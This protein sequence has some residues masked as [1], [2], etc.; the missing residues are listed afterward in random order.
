M[1]ILVRR[2]TVTM[3]MRMPRERGRERELQCATEWLSRKKHEN[4]VTRVER[5]YVLCG[6]QLSSLPFPPPGSEQLWAARSLSF[7]SSV[8]GVVLIF[9]CVVMQANPLTS[10]I[11]CS[12][13]LHRTFNSLPLGL[14]ILLN[15]IMTNNCLL[16]YI[17]I[18]L[19]YQVLFFVAFLWR[20][21]LR[22]AN[23]KFQTHITTLVSS[24]Y[25]NNQTKNI[26]NGNGEWSMG[27][28]ERGVGQSAR[29][30]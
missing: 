27:Q 9:V 3:W 14:F 4:R 25:T 11:L 6:R 2:L 12:E 30:C 29:R 10:F 7:S 28:G 8:C 5:R 17:N 23:T 15:L 20:F 13:I 18:S 1:K 26:H 24:S 22:C 21:I 16:I 19:L